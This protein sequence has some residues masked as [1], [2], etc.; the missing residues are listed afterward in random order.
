MT[1]PFCQVMTMQTRYKQHG[2]D[3]VIYRKEKKKHL[4]KKN[5]QE[6]SQQENYLGS[7]IKGTMKNIGQD[8]REIGGIGRE[9]KLRDKEEV[10]EQK[11]LGI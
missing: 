3:Y 4:E 9:N 2:K 7:Q 6:D 1:Q 11:N 8:Q 5:C 10:I